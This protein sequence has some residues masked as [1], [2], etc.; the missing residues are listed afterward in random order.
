[1]KP[2]TSIVKKVILRELSKIPTKLITSVLVQFNRILGRGWVPELSQEVATLGKFVRNLGL[3]N[4]VL[5]DIGANKGNYSKELLRF[6]PNT[7]IYAFEPSSYTFD[8]L[9]TKLMTYSVKQETPSTYK[10]FR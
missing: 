6:F 5:L 4:F 1:M 10:V 3:T 2:I 8:V 7:R 9:K